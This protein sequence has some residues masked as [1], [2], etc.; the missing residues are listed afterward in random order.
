MR[1]AIPALLMVVLAACGSSTGPGGPMGTA[2]FTIDQASCTWSGTR[3]VTFY[4]AN[5]SVGI[6]SLSRGQTSK[7][8]LTKASS[9]YKTPGSP[10]IQ[11]RIE[12]YT[13]AGSALWTHRDNINIPENGNATH[14][15]TC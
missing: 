12:N 5:D 6:E 4:I 9:A 7:G 2:Y 8:Y 15:F 1:A 11:A 10:V 13:P 3:A 14:A